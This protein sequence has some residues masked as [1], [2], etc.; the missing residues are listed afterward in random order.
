MLSQPEVNAW[1]E[2]FLDALSAPCDFNRLKPLMSKRVTVDMP[3]E[4]KIKKFEDW[5]KKQKDFYNSFKSAKRT[6]VKGAAVIAVPAKKDEVDV[7]V[8]QQCNFAWTKELSERYPNVNLA[9]GEKAKIMAFDRVKLST[10][11]ECSS[12]A[13]LFAPADFKNADRKDD[14][15]SWGFK[16]LAALKAGDGSILDDAMV[17]V[18]GGN[19]S[20]KDAFLENEKKIVGVEYSMTTG[21]MP[22]I[23]QAD[24]DN[25]SEAIVPITRS[26]KWA[27]AYTEM[28]PGCN[29]SAGADVRMV[30]YE[31]L[32]V[33]GSKVIKAWS[34]CDP[35][36]CIKPAGKSGAN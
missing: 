23:G 11:S 21:L 4:P 1:V 19:K 10:K 9:A 12:Y 22:V 15:D 31:C 16:F 20:T 24:K 14:E 17:F 29:F 2:D 26:F 5:E 34:H 30:S 18:Q 6:I 3:G 13:P 32:E 7:I 8:P 25:I 28:F 27:D 35:A 33:K 36:T